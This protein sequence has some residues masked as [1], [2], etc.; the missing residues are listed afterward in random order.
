MFYVNAM[1]KNSLCCVFFRC[2]HVLFL[3]PFRGYRFYYVYPIPILKQVTV[4][5]YC[6]EETA[7]MKVDMK[8]KS[9]ALVK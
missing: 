7:S 1:M 9:T 8:H 2:D 3:C 4:M 5:A 6:Y